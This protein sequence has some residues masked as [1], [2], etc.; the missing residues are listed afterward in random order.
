MEVENEGQEN[1]EVNEYDTGSEENSEE[2]DEGQEEGQEEDQEEAY[3]PTGRFKVFNEEREFDDFI[4]AGIQNEEQEQIVRELYEKASGL[5]YV[6]QSR[7]ELRQVVEHQSQ[8]L[9]AYNELKTDLK[10]AGHFLKNGDLS[11]FLSEYGLTEEK[12]INYLSHK[13]ELQ[14]NPAAYQ[15]WS[16]KQQR[17]RADWEAK[18]R[19]E[20]QQAELQ[21]YQQKHESYMVQQ[22]DVELNQAMS[23]LGDFVDDYDSR[24]GQGAFKKAVLDF[25][26]TQWYARK[27]DVPADEAVQAVAR[28]AGYT[29]Q[30]NRTASQHNQPRGTQTFSG[31]N[32]SASQRRVKTL[33]NFSGGSDS[34]VRRVPRSIDDIRRMAQEFTN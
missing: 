4:L 19:Y 33:P 25:G 22:R 9:Q 13:H 34:P 31:N 14:Q 20:A 1:T 16:E 3:T 18:Q 8:E 28:M 24:L 32:N 29:G 12:V 26:V 23:T 17:I 2:L 7:D 10:R 11:S 5:E 30:Q 15:V 21:G 6:K 27:Y